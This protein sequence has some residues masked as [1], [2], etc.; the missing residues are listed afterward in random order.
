[1]RVSSNGQ[2]TERQEAALD[3]WLR[4]HSDYELKDL[5][6]QHVSGRKKGRLDWFFKTPAG[7]VLVVEDLDRFSR[8]SITDGVDLL[9][10]IFKSGRFIAVCSHRVGNGEIIRNWNGRGVARALIDEFERAREESER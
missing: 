2:T 6:I 9:H 1:M 5:V 4:A 8:L 10:R 3:S 7:S